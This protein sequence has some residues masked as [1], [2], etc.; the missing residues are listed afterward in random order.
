MYTRLSLRIF[1]TIL[2]A[3]TCITR[4]ESFWEF[5]VT[6]D[7]EI[8]FY[9]QDWSLI[10]SAAHQF[11]DLAGISFDEVKDVVYFSDKENKL[12]NVFSLKIYEDDHLNYRIKELVKKQLD[13]QIEGLAFDPTTGVLYWSDT[14]LHRIHRWDLSHQSTKGP[15]VW[16]TFDHEV[17]RGVAI[18]ACRQ[19][20][21]WTNNDETAPSIQFSGVNE[22]ESH[23]LIS[24]LKNPLAVHVDP[25][26]E[27]IYWTD[28]VY[29]SY[30]KIE[31]ADLKGENRIQHVYEPIGN[32]VAMTI[33]AENIYFACATMKQIVQVNKK[34]NEKRTV[35]KFGAQIPR[36]II[37]KHSFLERE[38]VTPKCEAALKIV[39]QKVLLEKASNTE[40]VSEYCV[41]DGK[42]VVSEGNRRC[43]CPLGFSGTRCELDLCKN[44]CLNGGTCVPFK[45][46]TSKCEKCDLGYT[47]LRCEI[48]VC[49]GKCLNGGICDLRDGNP[50]CTCPLGFF[51]DK[52][53][54]KRPKWDIVCV[55]LCEDAEQDD[56]FKPICARCHSTNDPTTSIPTHLLDPEPLPESQP[57][58]CLNAGFNKSLVFTSLSV[59]G[60]LLILS[61]IIITINKIHKPKR[62]RVKKTYV[63]QRNI[64]GNGSRAPSTESCEII[65]ENCCN[66]NICETPCFDPKVLQQNSDS[67][68]SISCKE[69]KKQLLDNMDGELY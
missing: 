33:D 6:T 9:S 45:N 39:K 13:E 57:Q 58:Q 64:Q 3:A 19:I 55:E 63:V 25:F 44:V 52:C 47:G 1:V 11:R 10:R 41:N 4:V 30:Y 48:D 31:S 22:T 49:K 8:K 60:S 5:A 34:T 51:G 12:A 53:E 14:R 29:G 37:V 43:D 20:V 36:G 15:E 32:P 40:I 54:S 21:Y 26:E 24:G 56:D 50:V 62:P 17:P 61:L 35:V 18:D 16:K 69:D 38:H 46:G 23:T 67:P 7:E 65:I 59:M 68:I 66:M 2:L 27:R 42:E 28:Y